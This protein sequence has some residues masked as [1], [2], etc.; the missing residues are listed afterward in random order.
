MAIIWGWI[1]NKT[2]LVFLQ[3][4]GCKCT[5]ASYDNTIFPHAK[6]WKKKILPRHYFVFVSYFIIFFKYINWSHMKV[7]SSTA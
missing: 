6:Q 5:V 2:L 3:G 1:K 7:L 4:H